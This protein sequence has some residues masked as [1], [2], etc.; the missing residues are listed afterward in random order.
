MTTDLQIDA[1]LTGDPACCSTDS[2]CPVV[3][4]CA[5]PNSIYK[6]LPGVVAYD[7][8]RDCPNIPR[9]E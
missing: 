8:E 7:K 1:R 4:L 6:T 2:L 3:V 5:A 9:V